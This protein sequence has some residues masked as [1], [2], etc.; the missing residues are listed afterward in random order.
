[1]QSFVAGAM[2]GL[3]VVSV[4]IGMGLVVGA[5]WVSTWKRL[6]VGKNKTIPLRS[7]ENP[8]TFTEMK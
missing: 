4:L 1:M 6:R 8:M 2:V 5:F 3:A 7:V